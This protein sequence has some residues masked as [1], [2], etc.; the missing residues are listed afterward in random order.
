MV[1]VAVLSIQLLRS[2]SLVSLWYIKAWNVTV[3]G[4]LKELDWPVFVT[5]MLCLLDVETELLDADSSWNVKAH[6]DA[7]EDKWR[8]NWRMEWAASIH[9]TTSEHGVSSITNADAYT[10]AASSRL[11]WRSR[12]FKWTRPFRQKTKSGFCACV[13]T[14]QLASTSIS[15]STTKY[16]FS[17]GSVYFK[18]L[19]ERF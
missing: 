17:S 11:N 3:T 5:E 10:S 13:I 18:W 9:H 15:S 6:V 8:G 12:Q 1:F 4:Q 7:W 19:I 2:T 16:P 14:F